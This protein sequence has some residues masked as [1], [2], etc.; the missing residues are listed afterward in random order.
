M[1]H[2]NPPTFHAT[3]PLVADWIDDI[4]GGHGL[5]PDR[6]VLGGFSQG[7]VMSYAL[8]LGTGRPRPAGILAFSGFIPT[9]DS[10][11]LDISRAEGLPVAIGHG[12]YDPV[13]GV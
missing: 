11:E 5:T 6:A 12:E 1:A 3:Y 10:F 4:L 7:A 8:G 2:P 13:I 9:V